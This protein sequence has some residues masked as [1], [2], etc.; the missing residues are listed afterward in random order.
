MPESGAIALYI[1]LILSVYSCIA[2]LLGKIRGANHLIQSAQR[3]TYMVPVALGIATLT[4]VWGFL[5]RDFQ[6]EY[7]A[8]HSSLAMDPVYT[9]V[10]FYAGNEGSLLFVAMMLSIMA[11]GAI[12][13]APKSIGNS[14]P[15]TNAILAGVLTFFV[16]VTATM[17]NPFDLLP[18]T[19]PDGQGINPLLTH[20]GM[21]I[22][23][24]ILMT[25]LVGMTIPF[26][27]AMGAL[28][29]GNITDNWVDVG[30]VWGLLIWIMLAIGLLLGSWW[31]Y[32]I[33]GWGGYWAW[34]PIENVAL[35]PWLALT[36]FIHSI[37]VQKRR[38][39]FRMWNVVLINMAFSL[40]LFGIFIN[41]GGPV[42][43]V[44][45]FASSS[46]GWV[47]VGFLGLSFVFSFSVFFFRFSALKKASHIDS[48]LSREAAFLANNLL[49]LGIAFVTL[50]GVVFPLISQMFR[51]VTVT[52]GAPFYN[53]VNG[54]LF[55]LLIFLMG[56]GPLLPWRQA[57][58]RSLLKAIQI[59]G[60]IGLATLGVLA[61]LGIHKP[62]A[63][64]S[65]G[66]IAFVAASVFQEWIR[67]TIVRHQRGE[68]YILAFGKLISAN[69]PRYGGYIAHLAIVT[70][71][72]GITG[73][74]FYG[75]Q[76]DVILASGE[77]VTVGEYTIEYVDTHT[78]QRADRTEF[79]NRVLVYKDTQPGKPMT[80]WR[81]FYPKVRM[82]AT[83]AAIISTPVEDLYVVSSES[84]K[85]GRVAFRILVNPLV[86]WM[87]LA[88]PILIL[89]TIVALWPRRNTA[90]ITRHG[91]N[92]EPGVVVE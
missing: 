73:S 70:L 10:A 35:M 19:P 40:A 45:S 85:D 9:W 38:G 21:F 34:D 91:L 5:Q 46:L 41:R 22:H 31:A 61:A 66:L 17:A 83:R 2:S 43:S 65:F 30:R 51:G 78:R 13:W 33:L 54:P 1:A 15:Y 3:A 6:I 39:I 67:G 76:Q 59:P 20:P 18:F 77:Q 74:S 14:L 27:I 7:V 64:I 16:G 8:S 60:F 53:Q 56:I 29:S 55:M 63:L 75:I 4:L 23:P 58:M 50:W 44:H 69:R 28:L 90:S 82:A 25:G 42:P 62:F 37:M 47:F 26:A 24:P 79:F 11:A 80:V 84:L 71:A 12:A 87:W 92:T 86:W 72:L 48:L 36:A 32:T 68:N 49:L 89:G 88:G 81:A 57:S 52:V